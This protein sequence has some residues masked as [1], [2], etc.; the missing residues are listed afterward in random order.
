MNLTLKVADP[1]LAPF[2]KVG[3]IGDVVKTTCFIFSALHEFAFQVA[4]TPTPLEQGGGISDVVKATFCNF[5]LSTPPSTD[6]PKSSRVRIL[7]AL[8]SYVCN[9]QFLAEFRL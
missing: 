2:E 3:M 9:I 8:R 5:C 7:G 1:P 6:D 4:E